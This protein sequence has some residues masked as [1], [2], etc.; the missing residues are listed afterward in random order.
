M[1]NQNLAFGEIQ[2]HGGE[3]SVFIGSCGSHLTPGGP[4]EKYHLPLASG[5][6]P[7]ITVPC[8]SGSSKRAQQCCDTQLPA[9]SGTIRKQYCVTTAMTGN[10]KDFHST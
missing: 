9:W 6:R 2:G 5:T 7:A 10:M 1:T 4:W 3:A 8:Y